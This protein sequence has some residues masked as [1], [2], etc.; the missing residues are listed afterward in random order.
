MMTTFLLSAQQPS[1][2]LPKDSVA[3]YSKKLTELRQA[4]YDSMVN[5]AK[6]KELVH[7]LSL[8]NNDASE[9]FGVEL[10]GHLGIQFYRLTNINNRLSSFGLKE[11][12]SFFTSLGFGQGFRFNKLIIGYNLAFASGQGNKENVIKS[13][14][15][16]GYVSTNIFKSKKWI[17]S[18]Q[19][20]IGYQRLTARINLPNTTNNFDLF[21]TSS[22][23]QVEIFNS[24]N[25]LDFA[26]VFK[27][28]PDKSDKYM[29]LFRMG[30][31]PALKSKNWQVKGGRSDNAPI[32][33]INS[34]YIQLMLGAGI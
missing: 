21:F 34:F 7:K 14:Y 28:K 17:F 4:H 22:P 24:N 12:K 15:A 31:Q 18:P 26:F 10:Y 16:Q 29:P 27:W 19:I 8:K 23:N 2:K 13:T 11:F 32:D 6:Y 3:Y 33:R 25:A 30:Y 20:G 1:Q 5:S 9:K